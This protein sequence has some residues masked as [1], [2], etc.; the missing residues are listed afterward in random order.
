MLGDVR[1][2]FQLELVREFGREFRPQAY[3]SRPYQFMNFFHPGAE[4]FDRKHF[5]VSAR[6][7]QA[8]H[9]GMIRRCALKP[10]NEQCVLI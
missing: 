2:K 9:S 3:Q 10:D 5:E 6:K 1:K 4:S 7:S 8:P